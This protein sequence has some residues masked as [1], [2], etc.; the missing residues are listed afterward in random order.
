[1]SDEE[2]VRRF[3][4]TGDQIA[5]ETLVRR[6]IG[7]VRRLIAVVA[8]GTIEDREDLEQDILAELYLA[9]PR[10][11]GESQFATFLYRFCRNKTIDAIRKQSRRRRRGPIGIV[12]PSSAERDPEGA[13]IADET[14]A[15]VRA[16]LSELGEAE[17]TMLYLKEADDMTIREISHVLGIPDG[18]VKSRLART[19]RKLAGRLEA[20]GIEEG[21]V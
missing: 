7:K 18:T 13:A 12:P 5:F 11:R 16:V 4:Q 17:R 8:G 10:F 15:A 9:L 6:H 14:A 21:I 3:Q 19:R 1:M 2:L 20:L